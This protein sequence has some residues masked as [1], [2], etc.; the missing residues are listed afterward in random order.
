MKITQTILLFII[1]TLSA[2]TKPF[3]IGGETLEIPSPKGFIL[4]TSQMDALNRLVL[5]LTDPANDQL[6]YYITKSDAPTAISGA[7]PPLERYCI[8]KVGKKIKNAVVSTEDFTKLKNI[9]KQNNKRILKAAE[10]KIPGM[11]DKMSKEINKEFGVELTLKVSEMVPYDPH[12]ETDNALAYSM[13]MNYGITAEGHTE[14]SIVSAT[15]IFVN[16]GGKVLFLYCYGLH[17]EIEWTRSASKDWVETIVKNNTPPP[18]NSSGGGGFDWDRVI[19]KAIIGGIIG[20]L[21][22]LLLKLLSRF[23]KKS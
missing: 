19:E 14:D 15:I 20:G 21:I 10:A 2:N 12:Y 17:E 3:A 23:K 7:I 9:V 16:V 1:L 13:H 22:G 5:Q 11:M 6:A 4:V 8:L 18:S